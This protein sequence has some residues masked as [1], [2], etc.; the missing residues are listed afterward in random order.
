MPFAYICLGI[1]ALAAVAFP[2][3]Q[4][5]KDV[6]KA[7]TALIGVGAV[8]VLFFI[9]WLLATKQEFVIGDIVVSAGQM[10][11]VEASI[12]TFY[13][14]LV[15]AVLGILYSSVSRYFIK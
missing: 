11:L 15:V 2:V 13:S 10:R 14:L 8:A 7:M 6:K 9:C 3:L 5:V 1:A 4:M 12:F